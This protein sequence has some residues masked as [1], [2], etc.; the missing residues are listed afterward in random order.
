MDEWS[1][2]RSPTFCYY[3]L[4]KLVQ[5]MSRLFPDVT[6]QQGADQVG[7]TALRRQ[8]RAVNPYAPGLAG[9]ED[10]LY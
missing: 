3:H 10:L 8:H 6:E 1:K 4:V 2:L 5:L 7:F 9:W